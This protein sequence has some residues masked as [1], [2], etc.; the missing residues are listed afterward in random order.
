LLKN[1]SIIAEPGLKLRIDNEDYCFDRKDVLKYD[2]VRKQWFRYMQLD[3]YVTNATVVNSKLLISDQTFNNFYE[4]NLQQKILA[5]S[6]LPDKIIDL[7]VNPIV[8]F[9]FEEGSQGCFHQSNSIRSFLRKDDQFIINSKASRGSYL[10]DLNKTIDADIID[11]LAG[12]IDGFR[13]DK[14]TVE[15]LKISHR[16]IAH[17]KKYID[18]QAEQIKKKG[19]DEYRIDETVYTFPGEN[20]DFSYYKQVADS[21]FSLSPEVISSTFAQPD[22]YWST[23]TN[24]RRVIFIFKDG[25]RLIA[26]NS[27]N[28]PNYLFMPWEVGYEQLKLKS[29]SIQFSQ[30]IDRLT[31]GGF[32]GRDARD[33]NYAIFRIADYLYRQRITK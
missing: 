12:M 3:F 11:S 13:M 31:H 22:S 33:K 27:Y 26:G 14:L 6:R 5:P 23:T 24:T 28:H 29:N 17:F 8:E 18:Q 10:P 9:H 32:F 1:N 16:D 25:K 4:L 7:K 2:T 21:I 19:L 30:A 15:D 20:T